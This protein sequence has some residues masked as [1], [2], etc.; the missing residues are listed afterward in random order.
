MKMDFNWESV[1][2]LARALGGR[3]ELLEK[4]FKEKG[5]TPAMIQKIVASGFASDF[6]DIGDEIIVPWTD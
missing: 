4:V 3:V 1:N 5:L 2:G 6:F